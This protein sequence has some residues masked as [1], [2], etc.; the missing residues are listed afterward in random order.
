VVK[1]LSIKM[2]DG[3]S[4]HAFIIQPK[5]NPVAHIHLLHGMAEHIGRYEDFAKHLVEQGFIVSGHDH[6]GHGRTAELN[7]IQGHFAD[8]GGFDRAVQDAYEAIT[9]FRTDY[10]S[11]RFILFGHSMGSFVARRYVQLHGDKVD[12]AIFSGTGGDPGVGRYAGQAIAYLSGKKNGFN[13]PNHFLNNLVFGGF[14]K[15]IK[16]SVTEFDWL[17]TDTKSV[18]KY[19]VDQACGFVPTTRF[20]TDLFHGLGKIHSKKEINKIPKNLPLFLFSGSEDPVGGNGKG[21]WSV[22]RQYK[23]A[24]MNDVTVLLFEGGRHEMLHE[25]NREEVFKTIIDWIEKR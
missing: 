5:G 9:F 16:D 18:E 10:F 4:V 13:K 25:V 12:L 1:E 23:S 21:V 7:G 8:D 2:S 24:G 14:N 15:S 11:P 17:S 6:R 3:F 19:I 20:F 22:A